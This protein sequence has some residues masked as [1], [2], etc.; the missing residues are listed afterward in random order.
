MALTGMTTQAAHAAAWHF[1]GSIYLHKSECVDDGQT[2]EREGFP[3][4][5]IYGKFPPTGQN[6]YWLYIY[7]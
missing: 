6:M 4:K 7:N 2:Y 1:T 3:Y 5:C